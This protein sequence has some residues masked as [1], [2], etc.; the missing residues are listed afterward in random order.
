MGLSKAKQAERDAALVQLREWLPPG[1]TVYCVLRHVSR[2]GMQREISLHFIE[3]GEMRWASGLVARAL[4]MR[5]G[6]RDGI[7]IGG[8]GMDMGFALVHELAYA[9]Y[10]GG[11][12]CVG[13]GCP[14]ND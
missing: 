11:F 14:S 5:Q 12:G 13:E 2:S 8:C 3:D 4:G 7:V 1:S 10:K 6:K 9:L